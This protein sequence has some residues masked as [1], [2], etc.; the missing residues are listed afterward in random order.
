MYVSETSSTLYL[1]NLFSNTKI[2]KIYI[3]NINKKKKMFRGKLTRTRTSKFR[4]S[5]KKVK[6]NKKTFSTSLAKGKVWF[7]LKRKYLTN[8]SRKFRSVS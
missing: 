5:K 7:L 4:I 8:L 6:I 3:K 1:P 2:V